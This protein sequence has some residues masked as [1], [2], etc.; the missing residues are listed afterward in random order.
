MTRTRYS[1]EWLR[2]ART[3]TEW[4]RGGDLKIE[5]TGNSFSDPEDAK[6]E[7]RNARRRLPHTSLRLVQVV[8]ETTVLEA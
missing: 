1:I 3:Y 6:R 5:Q 7:L 8:T 2:R 4:L